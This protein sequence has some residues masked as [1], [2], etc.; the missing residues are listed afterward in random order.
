MRWTKISKAVIRRL[1]VYLRILDEVAEDTQ[2]ISSQ[3]LADRAGVGSA[4]VRKDLAWFGE[5]GKQGV[6]YQVEFLRSELRKI[7][8]LNREIPMG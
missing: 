1:P 2:L 3:E 6:G 8:N 5:F 7:L 4:L